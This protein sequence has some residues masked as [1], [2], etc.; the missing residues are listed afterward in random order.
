MSASCVWALTQL[1]VLSHPTSKGIEG[2]EVGQLM[3]RLSI[4]ICRCQDGQLNLVYQRP[5]SD[6]EEVF[7]IHEL[8]EVRH[9]AIEK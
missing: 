7:T 3:I 8:Q 1:I 9:R 2:H 5:D 4:S 6:M